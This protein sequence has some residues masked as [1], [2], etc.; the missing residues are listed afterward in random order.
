MSGLLLQRRLAEMN[1]A[2]PIVFV[3]ARGFENKR[4]RRVRLPY[5]T[6]R[7]PMWTSARHQV[8]GVVLG[9]RLNASRRVPLQ[10]V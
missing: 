9:Y 3:T 4:W 10:G 1:S 6:S 7:S 2:V 8:G 5:W